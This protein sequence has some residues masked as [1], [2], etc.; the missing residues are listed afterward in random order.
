MKYELKAETLYK[1]GTLLF[2]TIIFF[3]GLL[4]LVSWHLGFTNILQPP[5]SIAMATYASS[6][7]IFLTGLALFS[8]FIPTRIPFANI[9]GTIIVIISLSRLLELIFNINFGITEL[10]APFIPLPQINT[11]LMPGIIAIAF[12]TIGM[13]LMGSSRHKRYPLQS[14]LILLA[15]YIIILLGLCGILGYLVPTKSSFIWLGVPIN[16]YAQAVG[17]C[18]GIGLVLQAYYFDAKFRI[19]LTNRLSILITIILSIF[20]IVIS[21]RVALEKIHFVEEIIKSRLYEIKARI[22][23]QLLEDITILKQ[24]ALLIETDKLHLLNSKEQVISSYLQTQKELLAVMWLDSNMIT[25]FI[26]P[27][28]PDKPEISVPI[29]LDTK[30]ELEK[31]IAKNETFLTTTKDH[32][33]AYDLLIMHP[34]YWDHA[35]QGLAVFKIDLRKLFDIAFIGTRNDEYAVLIYIDNRKIFSINDRNLVNV[36]RWEDRDSLTRGNLNISIVIYPTQQFLDVI[37]NKM[38]IYMILF[39]GCLTAISIGVLIHFWQLAHSKI[40]EVEGFKKQLLEAEKEQRDTLKSAQIGTWSWDLKTNNIHL[41]NYTHLLLGLTPGEFQGTYQEILKKLV[42]EDREHIHQYFKKCIET[43]NPIDCSFGVIWP[44]ETLHW[45]IS[46]GKLFFNEENKPEKITGISWEITSIKHAQKFLEVSEAISK[47]LSENAPLPETFDKMIQTLYHYLNWSVIVLWLLDSKTHQ[48]RFAGISH[49][50]T[51]RIP[52]F[53]KATRNYQHSTREIS[54]QGHVWSTYRP[55]WIKDV[56]NERNFARAKEAAKDGLKGSFAFPILEGSH[57]IG[58]LE[59]FKQQ[60]FVEEVD[61]GLLNLMASIGIEVGQYIQRKSV[62]E[63]RSELAAIVTNAQNGIYSLNLDGIIKNWNVGAENIFGWK[64]EEVIGKHITITYPSNSKEEFEKIRKR[65]IS[66]YTIDHFQTQCVRKDG[67]HLW[68][69]NTIVNIKDRQ[70]NA[71][72]MATIVQ[73]ISKEKEM[74][75]ALRTNERKFRDF[76]ETTEEWFWEINN[77]L[78]FTYTNPIIEIILGY[79]PDEIIGKKILFLLPEET[80][81]DIEYQIKNCRQIR[82]GWSKR[83]T[84]WKHKNGS[85]RWLESNAHLIT[86]ENGEIIGFRGADRDITDRKLMEKSKNEF[87]SMVNHEL[88]TPLTSI[89]GALGL[90]SSDKT[91]SKKLKELTRIAFRNSERLSAL[92]GDILDIEKFELGKFKFD[93]KPTSIIEV[94]EECINSSKPI[95]E[96]YGIQIT[97]ET[98][99]KDAT[100]LADRRRL[101]QVLMNLFSNAF[102]FSPLQ[103][104]VFVAIQILDYRV[105]V[106][107]RDQG[108]G[109]SEEFKPRVFQKFAQANATDSRIAS[110]TGLGLNICKNLIEGMKGTISFISEKGE[111]TTFFFE[112]PLWREIS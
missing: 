58:I 111:G 91:L 62:E 4:F 32:K 24:F 21:W 11:A 10:V 86:D 56:S 14:I 44:N 2:A 42:P 16:I 20:A 105:R 96:K 28:H 102:K 38:V 108:I 23:A 39:G 106:S 33:D 51:I 73:D 19:S 50:P 101:I 104:S 8:L 77:E 71:V 49:I 99:F 72:A 40:K 88:R 83:V 98:N 87:I 94:V 6:L 112:L 80:R 70:G 84:S 63:A 92:I 45:V 35:F 7:N 109:I 13:I 48:I 3:S 43:D 103:S 36:K 81:E 69:D 5:P 53:E 85:I 12:I 18:I 89:H 54:L 93:L 27:E 34:T 110:G 17:M 31:P 74:D 59:L 78:I 55:T 26:I 41:D 46:K 65:V 1:I 52:E 66:G 15:S 68:V 22:N 107:I 57:I 95:A 75:E 25:R 67:S 79:K 60:P 47:I 82:E 30:K 61:D 37:S 9:L 97:K 76:V 29:T 100:V 64:A 90:I